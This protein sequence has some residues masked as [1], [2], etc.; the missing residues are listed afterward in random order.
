MLSH[1]RGSRTGSPNVRLRLQ[2]DHQ[3]KL[4]DPQYLID[5]RGKVRRE[6]QRRWGSET[7]RPRFP[8]SQEARKPEARNRKQETEVSGCEDATFSG[9]WLLGFSPSQRPLAHSV[10]TQYPVF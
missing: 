9:S 1:T 8:R 10:V 3:G 6:E 4:F 5:K 7:H 2:A